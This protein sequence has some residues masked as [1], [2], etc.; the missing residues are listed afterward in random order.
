[1]TM[2]INMTGK[3]FF[4][5]TIAVQQK[6]HYRDYVRVPTGMT[7]EQTAELLKRQCDRVNTASSKQEPGK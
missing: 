6:E 2:N 3:A 7:L 1:M 5:K 4:F